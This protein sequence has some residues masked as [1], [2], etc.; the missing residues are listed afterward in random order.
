MLLATE[1]SIQAVTISRD[2]VLR[3]WGIETLLE[4]VG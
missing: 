4:A 1:E 3:H 2:R